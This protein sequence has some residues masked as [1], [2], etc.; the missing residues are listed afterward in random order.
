[1]TLEEPKE[2]T[3]LCTKSQQNDQTVVRNSVS[4]GVYLSS[5]MFAG[6]EYVSIGDCCDAD[7]VV[8]TCNDRTASHKASKTNA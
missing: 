2:S 3:E 7:V 5:A 6:S 8:V 1:M 4:E